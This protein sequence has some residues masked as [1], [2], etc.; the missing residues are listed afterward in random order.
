MVQIRADNLAPAAI[1][2]VVL[3]AIGGVAA[4]LN[5]GAL[6]SVDAGRGGCAFCPSEVESKPLR[7]MDIGFGTASP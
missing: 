1:G 3:S 2:P 7:G 5:D 4:E 6:L